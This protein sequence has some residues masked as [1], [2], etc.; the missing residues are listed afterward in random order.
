MFAH[1]GFASEI[2]ATARFCRGV[3]L[4]GEL[5]DANRVFLGNFDIR[6]EAVSPPSN[7]FHKAGTLG[8]VSEGLTNFTDCFVEPVVEI[9]KSVRGP[10]FFLKFLTGYYLAVVLKQHRQDLEGLFLKANS[11]AMLVQFAGA[12]IQLE[13]PKAEPHAKVKVFLHKEVN[14]QRNRVYH[15]ADFTGTRDGGDITL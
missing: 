14:A 7:G 13:N 1:S 11:K 9:H 3:S 6:E 2:R 5:R 15:L 10:E 12:K 4:C 8:G